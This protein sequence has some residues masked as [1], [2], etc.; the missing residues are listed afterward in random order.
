MLDMGAGM[1]S[2]KPGKDPEEIPGEP[3]KD[4]EKT[5]KGLE[6]DLHGC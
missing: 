3:E 2:K 4:P 5:L 6:K 1:S